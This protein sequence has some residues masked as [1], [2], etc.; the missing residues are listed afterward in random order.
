MSKK[1]A[2][3]IPVCN[4]KG[5]I[6]LMTDT[7]CNVMNIMHYDYSITFVDDG[8]ND[9]TVETLKETALLNNKV[10]YI[11]LSRNFGHQNALK[12]GLDLSDADAVISMDGDL[13]HPPELIP[14]LINHWENGNDIVYTIRKDH[15]EI[16]MMKRKTS[17][18]FYNLMNR[19]S[20]IE[21]EAGTADFRLM[22]KRV[23]D[24]CRTF[25]EMDLFWRGLVKWIGFKQ[26]GIEYEPAERKFGKSKY[27]YK[28]MMQFA[29]RGIT[30]FSIKPLSIAIYLGFTFSILSLLYIPYT[31]YALFFGHAI[32]GWASVIVTIAFFGGLQLMILG[33]IGMYLGKLFIQSKQR[34]H[35]VIK[36]SN[37]S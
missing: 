10:F 1:I 14:E 20:D 9:G 34:P 8:S 19:L 24:I 2:I 5:N 6:S 36:E 27:T 26:L 21:L 37:L 25:N 31:I 23:V 7:L 18:M 17:N 28:K 3:V 32:N 22:D 11:S 13:Q 12:A 16:P 4:E 15:Q 30:S 35:Y 33:I 29:L